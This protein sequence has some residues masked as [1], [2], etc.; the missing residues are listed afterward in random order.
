MKKSSFRRCLITF[1]GSP[2][3]VTFKYQLVSERIHI[4]RQ[5]LFGC[6]LKGT[7]YQGRI[8]LTMGQKPMVP[9][10]GA[11][12][13][14]GLFLL[15]LGCSLG[16]RGVDPRPIRFG[17]RGNVRPP[18]LM[19]TGEHYNCFALLCSLNRLFEAGPIQVSLTKR[20]ERPPK[21]NNKLVAGSKVVQGPP[22]PFAHGDLC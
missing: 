10:I 4:L 8:Q 15:G 9:G 12:P 2:V 13:I 19:L 16:V 14:F 18:Y 11:P 21:M 3:E 17:L 7:L 20:T 22:T 6:I 1:S 5:E